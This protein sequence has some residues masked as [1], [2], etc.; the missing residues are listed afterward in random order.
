MSD[1]TKKI[2]LKLIIS[3]FFLIY[4]LVLPLSIM[5]YVQSELNF[6]ALV[7]HIISGLSIVYVI[8]LIITETLIRRIYIK[9]S[10]CKLIKN[11]GSE[12]FSLIFWSTVFITIFI[13]LGA[14]YETELINAGVPLNLVLFSTVFYLNAKILVTDDFLMIGFNI[15]AYEDIV[16]FSAKKSYLD[17]ATAE[18]LLKNGKHIKIS[19]DGLC[20]KELGEILKK[21]SIIDE[22]SK[23]IKSSNS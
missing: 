18:F 14:F 6:L 22:L 11:P 5:I 21:H 8:S 13:W 20:I 1:K 4:L 12:F 2:K 10:N 19:N 23:E 15:L 17:N 3:T 9:L 16:S 7:L